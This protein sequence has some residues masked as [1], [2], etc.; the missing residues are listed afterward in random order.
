MT[1]PFDGKTL[2]GDPRQR[3]E[4]E[5]A[6]D[7]SWSPDGLQ[8]AFKSGPNDNGDLYVLDLISG[9]SERVGDNPEQD[10]AP[11]WTPR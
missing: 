10:T 2:T 3:T 6:Q 8:I 9:D 1:A 5:N 4:E 7:P 11:A